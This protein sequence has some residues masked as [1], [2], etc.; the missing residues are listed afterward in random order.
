MGRLTLDCVS[1]GRAKRFPVLRIDALDDKSN[2]EQSWNWGDTTYRKD[3]FSIGRD[4]LRLEGKTVVRGSLNPEQLE[5]LN[6]V[7]G[8]G[9]F[10]TVQLA[11]WKRPCTSDAGASVRCE[12]V[13][14]KQCGLLETSKERR[15]MLLQELKTLCFVDCASLVKLHGAFLEQGTVTTVLEFMDK[16]SLGDLFA[17]CDLWKG[18]KRLAEPVTAAI[19]YQALQGLAALHKDKILHRDIK[20][21]N[22]LFHSDG[23]LKLCDFGLTAFGIDGDSF[24]KTAVGTAAYMAP[25]R[26]RGQPYSRSSDLWSLGLVLMQCATGQSPPWS[27]SMSLI[28]LLVTVEDTNLAQYLNMTYK[29]ESKG[30]REII[31]GCLRHKPGEFVLHS[32]LS[33]LVTIVTQLFL[34]FTH[35]VHQRNE[36]RL[37]SCNVRHG[38]SKTKYVR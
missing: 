13:A 10:S 32:V 19:T 26:L 30:S 8:R 2:M 25:E 6:Q 29:Y 14:V 31:E 9:A 23:S 5:P 1:V 28:D 15:A 34:S 7:L 22:L 16:G 27:N 35:L 11:S 24:H 3:G 4:Y 18:T 36:Y 33:T 38:F 21:A 17:N 20:P 37:L 12:K